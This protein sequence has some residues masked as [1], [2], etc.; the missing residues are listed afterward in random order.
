MSYTQLVR[1]RDC[2]L[3]R[4]S[5]VRM[6]IQNWIHGA[7]HEVLYFQ[8]QI[9]S[10]CERKHTYIHTYIHTYMCFFPRL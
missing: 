1:Y 6:G 2:I 8:Y 4:L 10:T 9:G 5:T 7:S 3:N